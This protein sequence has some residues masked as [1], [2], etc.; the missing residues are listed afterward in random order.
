[1]QPT[2][3]KFCEGPM[4]ASIC[5]STSNCIGRIMPEKRKCAYCHVEFSCVNDFVSHLNNNVEGRLCARNNN[6]ALKFTE[7]CICRYCGDMFD[8]IT[9]L[10]RHVIDADHCV[11]WCTECNFI[12]KNIFYS[13]QVLI[14][15][16]AVTCLSYK[17][18][19]TMRKIS[20]II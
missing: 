5:Q 4:I 18:I 6:E 17:V 14:R 9:N 20:E 1:M 13:N 16:H 7:N 8:G 12:G 10:R 3:C 11:F 19:I 2:E 15:Q